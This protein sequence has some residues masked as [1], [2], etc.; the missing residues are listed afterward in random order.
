MKNKHT[1][2]DIS[3]NI[4]SDKGRSKKELKK[5]SDR[6]KAQTIQILLNE[7]RLG[8]LLC[9]K[10]PHKTNKINFL[11]QIFNKLFS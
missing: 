1:K 4:K 11:K 9:E 2:T 6:L 5:I 3:I 10:F 7:S 8:G